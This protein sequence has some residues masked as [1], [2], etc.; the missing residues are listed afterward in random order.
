MPDLKT[1]DDPHH[2]EDGNEEGG[3]E[4]VRDGFFR[5]HL[6]KAPRLVANGSRHHE[7]TEEL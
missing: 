7:R 3:D 1:E 4:E 6:L 5:S 2:R